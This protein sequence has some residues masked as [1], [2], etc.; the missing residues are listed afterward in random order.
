MAPGGQT[1][2]RQGLVGW[3]SHGLSSSVVVVWCWV[4]VL[5]S[6]ACQLSRGPARHGSAPWQQGRAAGARGEGPGTG[7]H[8]GPAG[9]SDTAMPA[10]GSFGPPAA[11]QASAGW[12]GVWAIIGERGIG[13]SSSSRGS[14]G[15]FMICPV[16]YRGHR[17]T[18][19]PG[20]VRGDI[21]RTADW[22]MEVPAGGVWAACE[23]GIPSS[24]DSSSSGVWRGAV[25]VSWVWN[26]A[27][28]R[29]CAGIAL[30]VPAGGSSTA[31]AAAATAAAAAATR[32]NK[33][34]CRCC[35]HT[36]GRNAELW[37]ARCRECTSFE[38]RTRVPLLLSRTF[39]ATESTWHAA[40]HP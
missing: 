1:R 40:L 13:D 14:G 9:G 31:A 2:R 22:R 25:A 30:G 17:C 39:G 37:P 28:R 5:G 35:F 23:P 6:P 21:W 7:G 19:G 34:S 38:E 15:S 10:A 33:C 36:S 8:L 4:L 26:R 16:L 24:G 29:P 11:L 32:L 27:R 12:V 3:V 20:A 18:T